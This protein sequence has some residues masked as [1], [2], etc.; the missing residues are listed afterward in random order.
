MFME[1]F[2][3]EI[4]VKLTVVYKKKSS[5]NIVK[6]EEEDDKTKKVFN[7]KVALILGPRG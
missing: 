2:K 6:L 3:K 4:K 1:N 5:T 7:V